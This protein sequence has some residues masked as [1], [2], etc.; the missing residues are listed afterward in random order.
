MGFILGAL[1]GLGAALAVAVYITKVPMPFMNKTPP[2]AA[3]NEAA[4][5]QKTIETADAE[6]RVLQ[7]TIARLEAQ[8]QEAGSLQKTIDKL[9]L[10]NCE[11]KD[12]SAALGA[13][14]VYLIISCTN[15]AQSVKRLIHQN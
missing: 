13:R 8:M 12:G 7:A 2:R 15:I 9:E 6:A 5:A 11:I 1:F 10:E 14:C 4:E 3:E